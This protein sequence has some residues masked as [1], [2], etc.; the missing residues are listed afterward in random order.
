VAAAW[1]A[2]LAIAAGAGAQTATPEG[3]LRLNEAVALIQQHYLRAMTHDEIMDR[4]LRAL[5]R[6]IDPY[7][8][9][10]DPQEWATNGAYLGAEFGGIGVTFKIDEAA[11]VPRIRYLLVGSAA[12]AAG[13]RR[14]DLITA[15]DGRALRGLS[16]DGVRSLLVGAPGSPVELTLS[17]DGADAPIE[18]AVARR[19]VRT[20]TVRGVRRDA[21]GKS[22]YVLDEA[23][24]IGY[25]RV[26]RLAEEIGIADLLLD[27]GRLLTEVSRSE[28]RNYDA[29]PGGYTRA[30]MAVLI[31]GGTAS[32]SEFLAAALQDNGRGVFIGQRTYGKAR[33]QERLALSEGRGGLI[34]TTGTF[35]RPSGKSVDRHDTPDKPELAGVAPDAGMEVVVEGEEYDAW[36][37]DANLRDS[38][39]ILEASDLPDAPPDRVLAR[40]VEV[41][42][43]AMARPANG[44][45]GVSH[46]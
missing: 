19:I 4:A 20:P 25:I 14:G 40:A 6:D 43:A 37:E 42:E 38:P 5:L 45:Q 35:Q 32:S 7:S 18:I 21:D 3:D 13:A 12:G 31:N 30:P 11:Q 16:F 33:I 1:S 26:S 34:L 46:P 27:S 24:G 29:K 10:L 44:P 23:L 8:S 15:V 36:W 17:R 41:L 39:A 2:L 28:T 22:D 9:Y